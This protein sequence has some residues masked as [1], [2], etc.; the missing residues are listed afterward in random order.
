MQTKIQLPRVK[1]L[2]QKTIELIHVG[3]GP[4]RER[5]IVGQNHIVSPD[6]GLGQIVGH[7]VVVV[8]GIVPLT[9]EEIIIHRV[10]MIAE[11]LII[12]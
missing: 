6:Q 3:G 1:Q 8:S 11:G 5:D 9:V 7:L 4:S 2:I 10:E 12:E